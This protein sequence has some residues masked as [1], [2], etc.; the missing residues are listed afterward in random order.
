MRDDVRK[1]AQRVIAIE[2][3]A[4]RALGDHIDDGF[5]GVVNAILSSEGRAILLGIGKSGIIAQKIAATLSSTGTASFFLH[6]AEGMHGDLGMVRPGDVVIA[7]SYSGETPEILCLVPALKKLGIT[8]AAMTGNPASSLA[9]EADYVIN[10]SVDREACPLGLVPTAS[11]TA[12]LVMGDALA[13]CAMRRRNFR[14]ED[15]V[16]VH[17]GGA[18]GR[19]LLAKV[20]ELGHRGDEVPRVPTTA[21]FAEAIAEMSAKKFGITAVTGDEGRL[22]GVITDGDVR[23]AYERGM[24]TDKH[25]AAEVMTREPKTVELDAPGTSALHAM[26]TYQ[27]TALFALDEERRPI[28]IIHIHDILGRGAAT[29]DFD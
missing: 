9:R 22:V 8:L 6:P 15:F 27:I 11:T 19:R 17:P 13:V 2:A 7:V 3:E 26:E 5:R 20:S 4:V 21:T 23:R 29:F 25:T 1:D 12:A 16:A 18:L 28:A 14:E 10:T 24:A